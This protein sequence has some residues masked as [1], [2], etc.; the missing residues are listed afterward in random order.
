MTERRVDEL[1]DDDGACGLR[2]LVVGVDLVHEHIHQRRA[3]HLRGAL[4]AGRRLAH[5]DAGAV[6]PDLELEVHATRG[7]GRAVDL[8]EA[9]GAGEELRGGL[10]VF[11]EQVRGYRLRQE[12]YSTTSDS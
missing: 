7:T 10:D 1:F 6:R 11:V 12:P 2:A 4:E 8:A 5:V 9:E 3:A